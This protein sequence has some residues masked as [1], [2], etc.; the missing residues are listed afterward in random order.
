MYEYEKLIFS[1]YGDDHI[2]DRLTLVLGKLERYQELIDGVDEFVARFPEAHS[3]AMTA[4]MKRKQK[5]ESKLES[6]SSV[7][8]Q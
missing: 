1:N 8:V 5:A 3:S 2:L 6:E 7:T 4:I